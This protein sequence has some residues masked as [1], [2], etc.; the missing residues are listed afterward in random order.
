MIYIAQAYE[1]TG[2]FD[3]A[4]QTYIRITQDFNATRNAQGQELEGADLQQRINILDE[5][6]FRAGQNLE[7]IFDYDNAIRYYGNLASDQR[8]ARAEGHPARLHDALAA[9]AFI[10]TN[11]GRWT[12]AADAWRAFIPVATA[13]RER[14]EAEYRAALIPFRAE[15]WSEAIRSLQDYLRRSP[16]NADNAQFRVQ[17]QYS[18]AISNQRLGSTDA[19]R[20]ALREVVTVFRASGQQ[21]GSPAAAWAAEALYRDLDDQVTAFTRTTFTRGSGE[22]LAQQLGRLKTQLT[23]IDQAA[24]AVVQLRGGEYSIGAITRQGEAHEHLATQEQQIPNLIDLSTAQ[25]A[26]LRTAEAAI[27]RVEQAADRLERANGN[28]DQVQSL[29]DRVQQLRDQIDQQ[30]QGMI[31]QVR[32]R[33]DEEAEAERKLA[34]INYGLAVYTAR[35]NNIPTPFAAR[36]LERLRAEDNQALTQAAFAQP[37]LPFPYRAGMFDGEAPGAVSSQQTPIATPGLV[38]E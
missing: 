32:Q 7:R 13:G 36:A 34:I 6:N 14:A 4:T 17:A 28:P 19:Y 29:R 11:L 37:N 31:D 10:T 21:P 8:L 25:Q 1:R 5:S 2:R 38:T 9:V 3:S 22:N 27:A 12:Q 24:T 26:Q 16:T 20:R 15:N 35:N 23:A 18:I 33:F 30:R